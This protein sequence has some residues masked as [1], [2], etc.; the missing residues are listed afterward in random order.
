MLVHAYNPS[1]P[2]D[3]AGGSQVPG[4]PELHTEPVSKT[5]QAKPGQQNHFG[6]GDRSDSSGRVLP[7]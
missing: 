2:D 5:T 7:S 4:Q 3:E 6:L 1:T